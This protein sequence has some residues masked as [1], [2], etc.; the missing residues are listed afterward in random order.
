MKTKK[1]KRTTTLTAPAGPALPTPALAGDARLL[2]FPQQSMFWR[3]LHLQASPLQQHAPLLFWLAEMLQPE[4]FVSLV[5][6]GLASHL[7]VCQAVQRLCL[8]TRCYGIAQ[9]GTAS[10]SEGIPARPVQEHDLHYRSFSQLLASSASQALA[11]FRAGEIDWLHID[12][13]TALQVVDANW[14]GWRRR[15][16]PRAVITVHQSAARDAATSGVLETLRSK[17]AH[18][19]FT[20]GEG[21]LVLCAGA[22]P[23]EGFT[24]LLHGF[25]EPQSRQFL[26]AVFARLGQGCADASARASQENASLAPQP[27]EAADAV[28]AAQAAETSKLAETGA[29]LQQAQAALLE[30]ERSLQAATRQAQDEKAR[31]DKLEAECKAARQA[32][33][34]AADAQAAAEASRR[35]TEAA[36]VAIEKELQEAKAAAQQQA[37]RLE[38]RFRELG[39]LTGM[40]EERERELTALREAAAEP[41]RRAARE[42]ISTAAQLQL[43]R[44]SGLFDADWYLATY[45]DVAAAGLPALEHFLQH[46]AA[47]MRNPS[48]GFDMAEYCRKHPQASASGLN[49]LVHFLRRRQQDGR[50]V[51]VGERTHA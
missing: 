49:P 51:R 46:G 39:T 12:N 18:V 47:E 33:K 23:A 43:I 14:A 28:Q 17:F 36:L 4:V 40:I 1:E 19:E 50:A 44:Q 8:P 9:A 10:A 7:S 11:R 42:V 5:E 24:R 29:A 20:H 34:Q 30:K 21:L 48:A 38:D 31:A 13:L 15:L 3:P 27:A 41:G 35:Q 6:P 22:Q 16:S 45:P 37:R 26:K 25:A 2:P 32:Q